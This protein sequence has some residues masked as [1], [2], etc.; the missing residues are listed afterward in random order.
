MNSFLNQLLGLAASLLKKKAIDKAKQEVSE[1]VK[2]VTVSI[3]TEVDWNNPSCKLTENFTVKEALFLPS[4]GMS[5]VPSEEEKKAILEIAKKVTKAISLLEEILGT[6]QLKVDVHAWMRP[7]KANI[8]GSKWNGMDYNRY[9]YETQVWKNLSAEE[10]AKKK[11]PNSP[12]KT[13]HAIDFH[14]I[15]YEGKEKCKFIRYKLEPYLEELGLRMEDLE[16]G[17]IH[18]DD[19]PVISKR[20]FKP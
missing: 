3:E 8:P 4:W 10:K 5:H 7:E 2:P 1:P 20:F 6:K 18:L 17:W 15:G 11:V 14:I 9:I 16:G 13:G 19:M 12:H